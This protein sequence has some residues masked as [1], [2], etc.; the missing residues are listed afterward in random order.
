VTECIACKRFNLRDAKAMA[1]LGFGC[2]ELQPRS[3]YK[4]AVYPR[5][6]T[7]FIQE[8]TEAVTTRREWLSSKRSKT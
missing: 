7:H 6:C 5:E 3:V 4:S 2:C 8:K 1:S